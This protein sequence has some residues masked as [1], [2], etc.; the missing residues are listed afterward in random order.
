[1][2]RL[3]FGRRV[4]KFVRPVRRLLTSPS[5][6]RN[7]GELSA[8][9]LPSSR[10]C[11]S[12]TLAGLSLPP[13]LKPGLRLKGESEGVA[14]DTGSIATLDPTLATPVMQP[15][16]SR[17]PLHCR[18]EGRLRSPRRLL[19]SR[20][21]DG[22]A[23]RNRGYIPLVSSPVQGFRGIKK[24]TGVGGST[25]VNGTVGNATGVAAEGVRKRNFGCPRY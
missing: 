16:F 14:K 20:P 3:K 15:P 12:H 9:P 19:R 23:A 8:F 1:M 21:H 17:A 11:K 7:N 18:L 25:A 6:R 2:Y 5:T 13:A 24:G 4:L 22:R 10:K